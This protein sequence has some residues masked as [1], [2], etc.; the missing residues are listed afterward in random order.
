MIFKTLCEK[1][2]PAVL[3]F[4]AMGVTG[5]SSIPVAEY[6]RNKYFVIMPTSTVYS[7]G[8][9]TSQRKMR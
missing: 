4:H 5:E 2:N 7:R 6:L 1:K 8:R 9:S 3:F